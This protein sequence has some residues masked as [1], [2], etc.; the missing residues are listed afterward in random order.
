MRGRNALTPVVLAVLAGGASAYAYLVDRGTISDADR[1]ARRTD[2]FPSLRVDD[3]RVIELAQG[4]EKF[5]LERDPDNAAAWS[6]TTA[7]RESADAGVVDALLRELE[8][9]KR[10]REVPDGEAAGFDVPRMRGTVS[11]GRLR[12]D[13]ALGGDALR[14]EGAAYMHIEGEGTFVVGRTLKVQLLRTADTYRDRALVSYG[15]SEVGAVEVNG[16][17]G[18]YDLERNGD[19]FRVGSQA[20]VRALRAAVE[21]V[22]AALADMRVE[23]FVDDATGRQGTTNPT[24][25]VTV[26]ARDPKRNRVRLIVGGPCPGMGG[27]VVVVRA[28]PAPV[29]AC[30]TESVIQGLTSTA[31]AMVDRQLVFAHSDEIEELRLESVPA[32]DHAVDVARRGSGWHERAPD[33]RDLTPEENESAEALVSDLARARALDARAARPDDR[34]AVRTRATLRRTGA[35]AIEVIDIGAPGPDGTTLAR[36]MDDGAIL[37]LSHDVARRFEPEPVTLH[38]RDLWPNGFDPAD[39]VAIDDSCGPSPERLE[40]HDGHWSLRTPPGFAADAPAA[41]DLAEAFARAKADAWIAATDDGTFGFQSSAACSVGLTISRG[42]EAGAT[43]RVGVVFGARVDGADYARTL[44]GASVFQA[45]AALRRLA[46]HPAIDRARL[47]IDPAVLTSVTLV[48]GGVRRV[49]G[50]AGS[51]LA[52]NEE[53]GDSGSD[54]KIG[55]ALAGFY[56]QDA[57]HSGSP[58]PDEGFDRPTLEIDAFVRGENG[59]ATDRRITI[60]APTGAGPFETYFARV[61]GVNATFA[62]PRQRVDAILAGW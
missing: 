29:S 23:T 48:H 42:D 45:P 18:G 59:P 44:E 60:G 8:L 30:V 13:F 28:E 26:R 51:Q 35:G 20:G 62:V 37:R 27:D 12:Y 41:A 61:S 33:D 5:V 38:G 39:V 47:R 34:I 22:F 14:P 17:N 54:E 3:V 53:E 21:R 52:R 2:L 49:I 46:S 55:A 15:A 50:G 58:L 43:S 7:R 24:L 6:L 10:I 9:A 16:A 40:I 19:A 31:D 1:N 57:V 32:A 25:A 11:V 4:K 56:A 36:R